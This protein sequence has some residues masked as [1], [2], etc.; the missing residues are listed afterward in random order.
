MEGYDDGFEAGISQGVS[1]GLQQGA[2]DKAVETAR[3]FLKMGLSFEQ[4][5]SGT[6]LPLDEV[7]ALGNSN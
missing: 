2:H 4:V 7:L 3:N 1:K 5:S 6:G